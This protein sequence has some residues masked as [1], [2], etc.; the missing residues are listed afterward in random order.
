[1]RT[2]PGIK[3]IFA[4]GLERQGPRGQHSSVHRC[5]SHQRPHT[6]PGLLEGARRGSEAGG[7]LGFPTQSARRPLGR[8]QVP[9]LDLPRTEKTT[10]RAGASVPRAPL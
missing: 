4:Q 10:R 8:G 1:M 9:P 2:V 6:T 3:G 5:A 7:P